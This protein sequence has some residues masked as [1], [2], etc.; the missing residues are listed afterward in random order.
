MLT[1]VM[2]F[3]ANDE[4][5]SLEFIRVSAFV[6]IVKNIGV[7]ESYLVAP[8]E[9]KQTGQNGLLSATSRS[10]HLNPEMHEI[11]RLTMT[12]EFL[13]ENGIFLI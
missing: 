11:C 6:T 7:L 10:L 8:N 5:F 13:T 1:R 9:E 2:C 12:G 4:R 3:E